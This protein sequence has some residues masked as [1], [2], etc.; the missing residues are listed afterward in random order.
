MFIT[1]KTN[2]LSRI[3]NTLTLKKK[4]IGPRTL[5]AE[6]V[7]WCNDNGGFSS[8]S[9]TALTFSR[10]VVHRLLMRQ[11]HIRDG[12]Y[13]I[14]SDLTYRYG[15]NTIYF[16]CSIRNE[17]KAL[18]VWDPLGALI[19]INIVRISSAKLDDPS[20][21]DLFTQLITLN[22]EIGAGRVS[23]SDQTPFVIS[24]EDASRPGDAGGT[25]YG[26]YQFQASSVRYFLLPDDK[27]NNPSYSDEFLSTL[28]LIFYDIAMMSLIAEDADTYQSAKDTFL[29][30]SGDNILTSEVLSRFVISGGL[31]SKWMS[32][33]HQLFPVSRHITMDTVIKQ[34]NESVHS[35]LVESLPLATQVIMPIVSESKLSL[36]YF[37]GFSRTLGWTSDF[38]R[39][40]DA[41]LNKYARGDMFADPIYLMTEFFQELLAAYNKYIL[42]GRYFTWDPDMSTSI[43]EA[44]ADAV[45]I[46][47]D[48]A[49]SL[50]WRPTMEDKRLPRWDRT[51]NEDHT[52]L[53][54]LQPTVN[55]EQLE[56]NSSKSLSL[57]GFKSLLT[58]LSY[59]EADPTPASDELGLVINFTGGLFTSNKLNNK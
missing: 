31:L 47:R 9:S 13:S 11:T 27:R 7:D 23:F 54:V 28:P 26:P 25:S 44:P 56:F 37:Y 46:A 12:V 57:P 53:R 36:T 5:I 17:D 10:D 4:E 49:F 30:R 52:N 22:R 34:W 8:L 50:V 3:K 21:F 15:Y 2:L 48:H 19:L 1:R 41:H 33:N 14:L 24:I 32:T 55:N 16:G 20:E 43:L 51:T 6:L 29:T 38:P 45:E 39:F 42:S 40:S 35:N 18:I 59:A 58:R